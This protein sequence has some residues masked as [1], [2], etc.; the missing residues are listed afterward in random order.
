MLQTLLFM[1]FTFLCALD[2]IYDLFLSD[3]YEKDIFMGKI[4]K[5][6]KQTCKLQNKL[7]FAFYQK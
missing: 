4:Y 1:P 2:N 3:I 6:Q 5:K 7:C